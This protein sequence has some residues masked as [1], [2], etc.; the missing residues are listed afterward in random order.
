M[1]LHK[2]GVALILIAN[3]FFGF[4][5]ITVRWADHM[6]Y[7]SFQTTFFRFTFAGLGV[8]ALAWLKW[9]RLHAVNMRALIW[10][11][12]FGAVTVLTY[13]L[14]LHW[15]TAAKACLL[16]NGSPVWGNIY[17]VVLLKHRPGKGFVP[18]VVM[19]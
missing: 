8:F 7:S 15:T 6:G 18:L 13:F 14:S 1:T 16:N 2:N 9:Q 3:L 10:R 11:G 17:A 19:A 4:L 12:L 5:P